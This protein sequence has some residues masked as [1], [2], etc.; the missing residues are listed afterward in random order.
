[1]CLKSKYFG[2]TW[3]KNKIATW[4]QWPIQRFLVR[5]ETPKKFLENSLLVTALR[6]NCIKGAI[7]KYIYSREKVKVKQSIQYYI[8]WYW[9]LKV[10]SNGGSSR[11]PIFLQWTLF[12]F[13]IFHLGRDSERDSDREDKEGQRGAGERKTEM[14][15]DLLKCSVMADALEMKYASITKKNFDCL[16]PVKERNVYC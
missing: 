1:M 9:I 15:I 13:D 12:L 8:F 2:T 7:F 14:L 5:Y 3:W 16:D 10:F 6:V 4:I 11:F